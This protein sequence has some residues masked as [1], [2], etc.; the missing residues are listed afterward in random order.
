MHN[1]LFYRLG[2]LVYHLRWLVL[3]AWLVAA[4]ACIPLL[5]KVVDVF[6]TTGFSVDGAP[7]VKADKVLADQFGY[8]DNKFIVI[9]N[10]KQLRTDNPLFMQKVKSSLSDLHNYKLKHTII[11][12]DDNKTQIS[13]DKHTAYAVI[14]IKSKTTLADEDLQAFKLMI[15]TP[16]NMTVTMGGEPI[17]NEGINEQTQKDLFSADIIAAP[18]TV[19]MMLFI[20]ESITGAL[21]P[22]LTGA[23]CAVMILSL[24][25]LV[26]KH[27]MLSIFTLNIALL[28][29]LCLSLD[30]ALFIISRFRYEL[31]NGHQPIVALAITQA[32]AGKAVF[33]SGLA[34]FVSLS[35]LLLFPINI[36]FSVGVGGLS[37]VF[38][39]V[40]TA[41]LVLPAILAV[42]GRNINFL[43]IKS[44]SSL[45]NGKSQFWRWLVDRVVGHPKTYF[46]IIMAIM[47]V[48]SYPITK[49]Q[50]GVSDY[51]ILPPAA[52]ARQFFEVFKSKFNENALTPIDMI[53][54][55][56]N[57]ILS[58]RNIN[59][60]YNL[61][62]DL[63]GWKQID[64]VDSIVNSEPLLKPDQYYMLYQMP[65]GQMNKG[66]K[67]LLETTTREHMTVFTIVS[68]Y[69][70][71]SEQSKNLVREL[72]RVN[73]GKNMTKQISSLTL[74]NME[75]FDKVHEVFP[76]AIAI[77]MVFT[78]LILTILLRSLILP[79]KAIVTTM[80]SLFASYGVLVFII[81]QGHLSQLLN[82]QAQGMLDISLLVI[83][84][85]ALFGFSMD[86]EVFLLTR[87]REHY[88]TS[89]DTTK[90]IV[91]GVEHS[92]RI[93]T[94]AAIIV[95]AICCAFMVADIVM[96]KAF[97]LGIAVA[98][99]TDAFLI[100][101]L[102]VPA[103]MALMGR[104]NWYMPAWLDKLLPR[105]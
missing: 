53:L 70:V 52:P 87:I 83:I 80:L 79:L 85:C 93:I 13:K 101:S 19:V 62:Q 14:M 92:S 48:M 99:F 20:F 88:D 8:G 104:L 103:V 15:K 27:Y 21:I 38:V 71:D 44:A 89:N 9:Y 51:H 100:R 41:N 66:I 73:T 65:K 96:V 77:V 50:F 25:Y 84:F 91:F 4:I 40:T 54:T 39:A 60:L 17:F 16:T 26:G 3:S 43:S 74:T 6:Q 23:G 24:L 98:I 12:P 36:L 47:C 56:S 7:S 28:L 5:P 94:S 11:Y 81:Q 82:F 105:L 45:E 72:Q 69:P 33:F 95:I 22:I 29:G 37:A 1:H 32:T 76:Y 63:K 55:V 18:L 31:R 97:G 42:L 90:S 86:Y 78:Y 59:R 67:T 30:Y 68:D 35:A 57:D 75:V 10:S 34:V 58:K 46:V 64:S 49:V 61:S 102:L 2:K